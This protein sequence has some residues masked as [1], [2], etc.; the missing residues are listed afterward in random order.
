LSQTPYLAKTIKAQNEPRLSAVR[1]APAGL[2]RA[3]LSGGRYDGLMKKL[4]KDA[5]AVGFALYLDDLKRL[6]RDRA[7]LDADTLVLAEDDDVA[8]LL[9]CVRALTEQGERVRVERT[10]PEHLRFGRVVRYCEG[11]LDEC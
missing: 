2:P 1:R 3:V 11:R 4:G 10:K 6:P 8:G 7:D 5:C 9:A